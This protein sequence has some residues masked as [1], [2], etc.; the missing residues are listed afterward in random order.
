MAGVLVDPVVG[1]DP[2]ILSAPRRGPN[3][4]V[5]DRELIE[6]RVVRDARESLH[7]VEIFRSREESG[8]LSEVRRVHDQGIAFPV[9]DRVAHPLADLLRRMLAVQ[10]DD[11]GV[12]DHLDEN[13][14]VVPGLHDALQVV[15]KNGE[16]R[17]TRRGAESQETP[18]AERPLF[19]VVVG[20][21]SLELEP[22]GFSRVLAGVLLVESSAS[23][24]PLGGCRR[25]RREL[26]VLRVDDDRRPSPAVEL[27]DLGPAIDPEE[28]VAADVAVRSRRAVASDGRSLALRI[29][30]TAELLAERELLFLDGRRFLRREVQLVPEL[31][32]PL[33]RSQGRRVVR[34]GKVRMPV[35]RS[36]H[37]LVLRRGASA[38]SA[39][40]KR[41][42]HRPCMIDLASFIG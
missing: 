40:P 2:G 36:L 27:E 35:G 4:R 29:A 5:F 25:E 33:E 31:V 23:G 13:H 6:N 3:R 28:I 22:P 41:V 1:R 26:P 21:R 20:T 16:R 30:R 15:V 42:I 38:A 24:G 9:A 17:R 7:H 10:R 32:R 37:G 19:R 14:H 11:A 18:L 8:S 34:P 12:V 39:M